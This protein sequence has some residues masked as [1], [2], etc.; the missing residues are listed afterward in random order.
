MTWKI[1][2][3][4]GI[5][6]TVVEW[7]GTLTQRGGVTWAAEPVLI[8]TLALFI[9]VGYSVFR[10]TRSIIAAILTSLL[11]GIIAGFFGA[12]ALFLSPN[13]GVLNVLQQAL[14]TAF[15]AGLFAVLLGLMGALWARIGFVMRGDVRK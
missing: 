6:L 12:L 11:S 15:S 7:L 13:L 10:M 14:M 3:L 8:L 5:L 2:L 1:G 9:Y 4:W